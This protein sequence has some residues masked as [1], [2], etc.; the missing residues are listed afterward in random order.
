MQ[1]IA[2]AAYGHIE[3]SVDTGADRSCTAAGSLIV[4]THPSRF[5]RNEFLE[6]E[7]AVTGRATQNVIAGVEQCDWEIRF[8]RIASAT[9]VQ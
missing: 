1:T 2:L 5:L 8:A 7:R 3:V 4:T 9:A 6:D